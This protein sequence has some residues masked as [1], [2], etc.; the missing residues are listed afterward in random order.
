MGATVSVDGR[1]TGTGLN[2]FDYQGDWRDD[3]TSRWS[4]SKDAHFIFRYQGTRIDLFCNTGHVCGIIAVSVDGGPEIEFD[5]AGTTAKNTLCF[6]RTTTNGRH[7]LKARLTGK[8]LGWPAHDDFMVVNHI[9]VSDAPGLTPDPAVVIPADVPVSAYSRISACQLT[10]QAR[11]ITGNYNVKA[12]LDWYLLTPNAVCTDAGSTNCTGWV[13]NNSYAKYYVDFG[14]G[15][16][17]FEAR[18]CARPKNA[19]TGGATGHGGQ[20][21]IRLDSVTG[22]LIGTCEITANGGVNEYKNYTCA[23]SGATGLHYIW[24]VFKQPTAPGYQ[25]L[26]WFTFT[27][28]RPSPRS[29]RQ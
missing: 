4:M 20:I 18:A 9:E 28:G 16:S 14:T 2:Q 13:E 6:R 23:V 24:L 5:G 11:S 3:G 19:N 17:G 10:T 12:P 1:T 27:G 25:E 29:S 7:I 8:T 15:A 26:N 22:P 21:E